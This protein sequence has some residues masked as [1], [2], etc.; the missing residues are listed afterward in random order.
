M[1]RRDW[2]HSYDELPPSDRGGVYQSWDTASKTGALNDFSVCTTWRV[3]DGC[4]YLLDVIRAKVDF[5][6]LKAKAIEA[7]QAWRPRAVLIEDAGV[8][9]GLIAELRLSGVSAIGVVPSASKEAR[10]SVQTAKFEA[11]RVL[12]PKSAPWP[13]DLVAELLAFPAGR[14]DDQVDSTVQ[15]LGYEI[16][17]PITIRRVRF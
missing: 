4:F 9:A 13:S 8:G 17:Q 5:P 14:H 1:F 7:A 11:K 10:A 6:A 12:L 2:L 3:A 15:M 16:P